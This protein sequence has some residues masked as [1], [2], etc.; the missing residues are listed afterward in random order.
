MI[1]DKQKE[2]WFGVGIPFYVSNFVEVL[3]VNTVAGST[4]LCVGGDLHFTF[5]GSPHAQFGLYN[6]D[7]AKWFPASYHHFPNETHLSSVLLNNTGSIYFSGELFIGNEATGVA[8]TFYNS[9]S[10]TAIGN[11]PIPPTNIVLYSASDF[12]QF[13]F[14]TGFFENPL[15]YCSLSSN[16]W[17]PA[18]KRSILYNYYNDGNNL[19][20]L[21]YKTG[22]NGLNA[23]NS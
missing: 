13:V 23:S 10:E 4:Y 16:D 11:T 19:N 21:I 8:M 3:S 20:L 5:N 2:V 14:A 15:M 12:N 22:G 1:Y 9:S 7:E 18:G 6:L 17:N